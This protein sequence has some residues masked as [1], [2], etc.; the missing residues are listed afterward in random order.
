[1]VLHHHHHHHHHIS[2]MELA[3]L[4][5]CSGLTYPEVS[6]KLYHDSFCQLGSSGVASKVITY[7]CS[8][9]SVLWGTG[10]EGYW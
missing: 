4:L 3:H 6:S 10:V 5:T 8:L 1:M 2:Y 9:Q 7:M